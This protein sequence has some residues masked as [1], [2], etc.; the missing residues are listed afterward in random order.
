MFR[1]TR[2]FILLF[3][4]IATHLFSQHQDENVL[5]FN[6]VMNYIEYAYV[7]TVNNSELIDE[8][9]TA[10]L[11]KLDPHS[12]YIPKQEVEDANERIRGDFVGIG[13]RFQMIKD[14]F[15][16]VSVI[17]GG[18]SEKV[19][20]M[21]NDKIVLVNHDTIAGKKLKT[22][23]IRKKL[24][25]ELNSKVN[26]QVL[27]GKNNEKLDFII[28]RGV[29]RINSVDAAYMVD[30]K[31]GYIKLNA[32]SHSTTQEMDSC[33]ALLKAQ[34]MKQ[35]ILDL[36]NNGG[37]L[38]YAAKDLADNFL[39]GNKLIVYSEGRKQPRVD[40][41][42][43]ER[44][45]FV[46][47]DLIILVNEFSA[48]ASEIVSGAVQDWDR[49]LI[50]G[51]RTFGK[52]LVQRPIPLLDGSEMRLTIARYYTPTGRNIQKPYDKGVEKYRK[53]YLERWEHGEMTSQD[54]ISF[55][56]S[57]KYQTL[58]KKRVVYGG[59]GIMPDVFTPMD[60]TSMTPYFSKLFRGGYFNTFA[61]EYTKN[62]KNE[63]K[64]AFTDIQAFKDGFHIDEA[65]RN[66]FTNFAHAE[67][68]TLTYNEEEYL[69][70]QNLIE[71]RLKA[72]I[73]SDI[74][75][76]ES[77]FH[78]FNELNEPFKKAVEIFQTNAYKKYQ[79]AN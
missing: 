67:D 76:F 13:V 65:L 30:K 43:G 27:R 21:D 1:H 71:T 56:D 14:T 6:Q 77:S 32:F 53:D 58:I 24:M 63:I 57:L 22:S 12:A 48:S 16:I 60:T 72:I 69:K 64:Q 45:G 18:P 2:I 38:M 62:H 39:S 54:S 42:A 59:G 36:Q 37:G 25:G 5:K 46:K 66:E 61:Y 3:L 28:T 41:N 31:I 55:P 75:G 26:I 52:G 7:D 68:S 50:V 78:I 8:A 11:E 19:G 44:K 10:V 40:L 9:I 49:G 51:R 23:E 47:G 33:I 79:L 73:A 29:I 70:D 17:P 20:L 34:G 74:Y 35:L 4:F 15:N